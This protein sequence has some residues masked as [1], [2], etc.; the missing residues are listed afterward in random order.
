[1]SSIIANH[2]ENVAISCETFAT[3]RLSSYLV[4][5]NLLI[6]RPSTKGVPLNGTPPFPVQYT[7]LQYLS[8]RSG[9]FKAYCLAKVPYLIKL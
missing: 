3:L 5:P 1:M 7:E 2:F 6:S 4:F 9:V 8:L